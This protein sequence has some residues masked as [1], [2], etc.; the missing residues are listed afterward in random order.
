ME[1]PYPGASIFAAQSLDPPRTGRSSRARYHGL[2]NTTS[3]KTLTK[4]Y[5]CDE[6]REVE[7]LRK[8]CASDEKNAKR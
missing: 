3:T 4:K 7:N 5:G 6:M 2:F 1:R 8:E